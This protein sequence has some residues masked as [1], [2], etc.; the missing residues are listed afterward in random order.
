MGLPG[1]QAVPSWL[2]VA[3][4]EDQKYKV[5]SAVRHGAVPM[6]P[7]AAV[8]LGNHRASGPWVQ[9]ELHGLGE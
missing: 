3:F 5:P 2:Q 4:E 6:G 1:G 9:L 8:D 7:K